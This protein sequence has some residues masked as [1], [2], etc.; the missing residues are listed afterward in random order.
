[1]GGTPTALSDTPHACMQEVHLNGAVLDTAFLRP[2]VLV[3]SAAGALADPPGSSADRD[4]ALLDAILKTLRG[5]GASVG[6]V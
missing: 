2:A 4:Q 5:N 3:T 6:C 1:M